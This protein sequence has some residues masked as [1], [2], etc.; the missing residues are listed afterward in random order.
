MLLGLVFARVGGEAADA[1]VENRLKA[2]EEK[3]LS[4]EEALR[5]RDAR[6]EKL[7]AEQKSSA[8]KDGK[9]S[10]VYTPSKGFMVADSE[11][12]E[13]NL[14]IFT[15]IRYLNQKGLDDSYTDSFGQTTSIQ[16][17]RDIQLNKVT[18]N[19]MG[20][21][22][23]P[24]FRYLFYVW[25]ANS[26]LGQGAQVV[27][28]GNLK[29]QFNEHFTLGGGI[30]S[31]P[32]VRSTEGSFPFWLSLDNRLIADEFFRPSYTTGVWAN[33]KI[34]DGLIYDVMVGNNLSQLGVDAGQL[35]AGVHTF[36]A[37][38]AYMPTTGEFGKAGGFGDFESHT[39][40]AS[41][42][43]LHYT[44]SDE[45]FQ[46]QPANT[47]SFENVQIRLSDGNSI[48][49]NNLFGSGVKVT[50]AMYHMVAADAGVKFRGLS[51]EG[52]TY[53][54]WINDFR[55]PGTDFLNEI[56]DTGFQLQA[57]AMLKPK[58]FQLYVSGSKI[59]G[60]Y[61]DPWDARAGFNY[62]PWKKE[63]V[64][65]NV[66]YIQLYQSPVGG[67]SLPYTVGGTGPLFH[68]NLMV[69]F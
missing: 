61:G 19:F 41:R 53:W 44:Q 39:S 67:L 28:A 60:D 22:M 62:F 52:E 68:V 32:G 47:D 35:D 46:G 9:P 64:R 34:R 27:V 33:G 63:S 37:K 58:T 6:I 18:L 7:E 38:L 15:Y 42:L 23:D 16:E 30:N 57:S 1:P 4:L 11:S 55:G 14:R 3:Q 31:L 56:Q 17:R 21:F 51:L 8:Q 40:L 24:R 13:M 10:S 69:N 48:F 26:N 2:L 65:W 54:R 49:E 20:W 5:A 66:E 45:N 12:G 36:S 29:Y 43:G 25:T 50:D 59:Y